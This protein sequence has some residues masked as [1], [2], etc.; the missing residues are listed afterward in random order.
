M[1]VKFVALE[2]LKVMV[3]AKCSSS[4]EPFEWPCDSYGQMPCQLRFLFTP[5]PFQSA[6]RFPAPSLSLFDIICQ[7]ST[8]RARSKLSND[9]KIASTNPDHCGTLQPGWRSSLA[10]R[11]IFCISA[12]ARDI[13]FQNLL[14]AH[15]LVLSC[16]FRIYRFNLL[17]CFYSFL[18]LHLLM[19]F[20][21]MF[22][23]GT[24]F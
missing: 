9:G 1:I 10:R 11:W 7:T 13:Y 18:T 17:S 21:F 22:C 14:H 6:N 19:F 8:A 23:Q 20:L 3:S 12:W 15:W 16:F 4:A 5:L 2:D 24:S